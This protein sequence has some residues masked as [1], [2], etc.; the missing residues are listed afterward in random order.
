MRVPKKRSQLLSLVGLGLE[1][2][3]GDRTAYADD[4]QLLVWFEERAQEATAAHRDAAQLIKAQKY[5]ANV[6]RIYVHATEEAR[7]IL[8]QMGM[9]LLDDGQPTDL[10]DAERDLTTLLRA[11]RTAAG[12]AMKR[13]VQID[14]LLQKTG[15]ATPRR[16]NDANQALFRCVDR[17]ITNRDGPLQSSGGV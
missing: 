4:D 12:Q 14:K 8:K 10:E 6:S 1:L 2:L 16:I 13:R 5:A 7:C 11:L 15:V 3:V 9:R 17:S